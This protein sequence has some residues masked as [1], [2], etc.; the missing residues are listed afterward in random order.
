[1]AKKV[2]TVRMPQDLA[3]QVEAVARGR[4]VSVNAVVLDALTAEIQRV[5]QDKQFMARLR[6]IAE[7]DKEILDR[8]AR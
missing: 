7:R 2:T 6:E 4:G 3:D 8:L 1:M 5:K